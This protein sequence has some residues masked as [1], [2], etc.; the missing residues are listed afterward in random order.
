MSYFGIFGYEC[1]ELAELDDF[2]IIPLSDEHRKISK[3]SSDQ[4]TYHLT[5]FLELDDQV[6]NQRELVYDLKAILSFIDRKDVIIA[7][8]LKNTEQP[9]NLEDDYPQFIKSHYRHN[10]GGQVIMSDTFSKDSRKTFI[11]MAMKK[12][13][14]QTD[15]NN[16]VF[17]SA[18]FK[19]IE[20][21]RA[22]ESFIDV[23]YYLL[24]SALESLSRAVL[25]ND[26]RNASEPIAI[27]LQPYGFNIVQDNPNDLFRSVSTYT[28]LRNALFHEGNFEKEVNIN[29]SLIKLELSKFYSAFRGLL[30]LVM[31]RY[32]GFDDD[33]INWNSW[34]DRMAFKPK[35]Q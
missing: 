33:H 3:L 20:I 14:D 34:I 8:K 9:G 27:F 17:R 30:P 5:A 26:S 4:T 15:P 22:R 32:I 23:D 7:N 18:F 24:F 6:H 21:F 25:N 19:T 29:G 11:E 16:E 28:H 31:M 35:S 12:L 1:T 10:G 13:S 2:K